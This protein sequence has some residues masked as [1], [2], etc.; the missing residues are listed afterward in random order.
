MLTTPRVTADV[1]AHGATCYG[2]YYSRLP[3]FPGDIRFRSVAPAVK[4][5][6]LF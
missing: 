4:L 1:K 2:G 3:S 6:H 5:A